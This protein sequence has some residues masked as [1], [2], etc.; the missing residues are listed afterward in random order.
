MFTDVL[1]E[2]RSLL[3]ISLEAG[4][5][6]FAAIVYRR[7][8]C[9]WPPINNGVHSIHHV[10]LPFKS[11]LLQRV[12]PVFYFVPSC[13]FPLWKAVPFVVVAAAG[14]LHNICP[15]LAFTAL[16]CC[17]KR[18]LCRLESPSSQH[19]QGCPSTDPA[20]HKWPI[21]LSYIHDSLLITGLLFQCRP[22]SKNRH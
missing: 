22:R 4:G 13:F 8:L 18:C 2:I 10:T 1:V 14:S 5:G 16:C 3:M 11:N 6:G 15:L 21:H 9:V 12:Q 19:L 20:F 7:C 17:H